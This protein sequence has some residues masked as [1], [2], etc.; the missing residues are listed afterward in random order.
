MK[1]EKLLPVLARLVT[2][3]LAAASRVLLPETVITQFSL[4]EAG[5]TTMPRPAAVALPTILGMGGGCWQLSGRDG[6]GR[7]LLLSGAAA[8]VF[9]VML[10]VNR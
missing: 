10:A 4:N 2:V 7:G 3:A 5:V 9:V 6:R 1:K 8:V